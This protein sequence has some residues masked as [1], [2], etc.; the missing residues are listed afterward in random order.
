MILTPKSYNNSI[1]YYYCLLKTPLC[2]PLTNYRVPH[3][4]S[5]MAR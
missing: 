1:N 5:K 2:F 3:F 4:G